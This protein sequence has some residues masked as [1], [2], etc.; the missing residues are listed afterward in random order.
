MKIL[1]RRQHAVDRHHFDAF[2]GEAVKTD[3]GS[4]KG[5]DCEELFGL[6]TSWCLLSGHRPL[7]AQALWH[8]LS[9]KGITP[10]KNSLSMTGPAATDFIVASAPSLA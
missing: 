9:H 10:G 7:S 1:A 2:L 6:Y 5:L 4:D 3:P 8:A